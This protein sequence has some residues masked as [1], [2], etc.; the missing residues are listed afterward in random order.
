MTIRTVG[1][2]MG[3]PSKHSLTVAHGTSVLCVKTRDG[4]TSPFREWPIAM[5]GLDPRGQER[6]ARQ[7]YRVKNRQLSGNGPL[8]TFTPGADPFYTG[9]KNLISTSC[10]CPAAS[11]FAAATRHRKTTHQM[12]ATA[13]RRGSLATPVPDNK[14]TDWRDRR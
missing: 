3:F 11:L 5:S 12:L 13:T 14:R 1:N 9:Q 8:I 10:E 4:A 6:S 2:Y 7:Q